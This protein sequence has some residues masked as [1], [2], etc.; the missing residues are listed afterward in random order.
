[1][2]G[3]SLTQRLHL[4]LH[5]LRRLWW[6]PPQPSARQPSAQQPS[7]HAVVTTGQRL[8]QPAARPA[9]ASRREEAQTEARG[10]RHCSFQFHPAVWLR[11][12]RF[13]LAFFPFLAGFWLNFQW[14]Y[15]GRA[16]DLCRPTS[17]GPASSSACGRDYPLWHVQWCVTTGRRQQPKKTAAVA[18]R[19]DARPRP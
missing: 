14:K 12:V 10:W 13:V 5:Q 4:I 19:P 2:P 8:L 15:P 3:R 9:A 1:M 18:T 11:R 7:A 6:L 17:K 16:Q